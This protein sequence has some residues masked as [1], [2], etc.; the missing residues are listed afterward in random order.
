MEQET[1]ISAQKAIIHEVAN[2]PKLADFYLTGGTAL[3]AYYLR[4][5]VSDDLDFFSFNELDTFFIHEFINKLK[6]KLAAGTVR[7]EKLH[8]RNQF[9]FALDENALD[10]N[11]LKVEFTKYP[12]KQLEDPK[13]IDGLKIDSLRDIGAN[14]MMALLERFD[15]KDFVDLYYLLQTRELKNLREDAETKFGVKI[16]GVFLGGE[17]TK[18]R[19]IEALPKMLKPLTIDELKNFF[20]QQIKNLSPEILK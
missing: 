20:S 10:E 8:D 15:P 14:K 13:T 18:V 7:F 17:L 6:V 3:A 5:R 16:G 9:Y 2:E 1:L 11:E 4:H 19:R 12:F